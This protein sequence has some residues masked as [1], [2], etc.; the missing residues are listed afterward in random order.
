MFY[1]FIAYLILY[2]QMSMWLFG[3]Y[4]TLTTWYGIKEVLNL[5]TPNSKWYCLSA[6]CLK[7]KKEKKSD[8]KY[9]I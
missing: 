2:Q 1:L 6:F 7:K 8:I 5:V 3:N 4:I 9:H